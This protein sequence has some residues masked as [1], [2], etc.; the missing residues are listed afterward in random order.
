V[1]GT[2][3]KLPSGTPLKVGYDCLAPESARR[4]NEFIVFAGPVAMVLM[5]GFLLAGSA[6]CLDPCIAPADLEF[7]HRSGF[8]LRHLELPR[9]TA[10]IAARPELSCLLDQAAVFVAW[11]PR[12]GRIDDAVAAAPPG[13]LSTARDRGEHCC[14]FVAA[15]PSGHRIDRG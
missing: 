3:E 5:S 12:S 4:A 11:R 8:R 1:L 7:D 13:W 9:R 6:V 14:R 15:D 10:E 2:D